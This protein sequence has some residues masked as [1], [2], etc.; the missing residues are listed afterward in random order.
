MQIFFERSQEVFYEVAL[1]V[2][3]LFRTLSCDQC[4][5]QVAGI[6]QVKNDEPYKN[7]TDYPNFYQCALRLSVC[8]R[9]ITM[10]SACGI[11][12]MRLWLGA[13]CRRRNYL[14]KTNFYFKGSPSSTEDCIN[15]SDEAD[16]ETFLSIFDHA[17]PVELIKDLIQN[18]SDGLFDHTVR[19]ILLR[20]SLKEVIELRTRIQGTVD[21]CQ[22][23]IIVNSSITSV[24]KHAIL[25]KPLFKKPME[26]AIE[27][28]N[29]VM[30][31]L[32][33]PI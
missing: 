24:A 3:E 8:A 29:F 15:F 12:V 30:I 16:R 32:E 11:P 26:W 27:I 9:R 6:K 13:T 28:D 5:I 17:C 33:T 21:R 2:D 10:N 18:T 4:N 22:D 20:K 19:V 1:L 31:G 14:C 25:K 7:Q 23:R